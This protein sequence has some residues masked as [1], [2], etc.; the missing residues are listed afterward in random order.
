MVDLNAEAM[1]LIQNGVRC[2]RYLHLKYFGRIVQLVATT[3]WSHTHPTMNGKSVWRWFHNWSYSYFI[4][5]V[6]WY[7]QVILK[8]WCIWCE[9]SYLCMLN[10]SAIICSGDLYWHL[11]SM[12]VLRSC[13]SNSFANRS[14]LSCDNKY[15][16]DGLYMSRDSTGMWCCMMLSFQLMASN[17]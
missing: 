7:Y 6:S 4:Y 3:G 17:V 12:I 5:F 14:T 1:W 13:A 2:V 16:F 10:T 9:F 11:M 8:W 15:L